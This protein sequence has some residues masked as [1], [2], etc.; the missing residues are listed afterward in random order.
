MR[1]L[2]VWE[3]LQI[4][5]GSVQKQDFKQCNEVLFFIAYSQKKLNSF[6]FS[7]LMQQLKFLFFVKFADIIF[8]FAWRHTINLFKGSVEGSLA[9]ETGTAANV[10]NAV[11]GC[12]H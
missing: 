7:V 5:C 4:R 9:G 6:P 1:Q 12:S 11:V 2:R 3:L 10:C 8:I